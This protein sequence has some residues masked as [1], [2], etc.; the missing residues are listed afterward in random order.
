MKKETTEAIL[1]L[2]GEKKIIDY[3]DLA[4]EQQEELMLS[5]MN[6]SSNYTEGNHIFHK[7][8]TDGMIL[9][10]KEAYLG[11][12]EIIKEYFEVFRKREERK[13]GGMPWQKD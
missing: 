11:I 7:A 4:L 1:K 12:K 10:Y 3:R 8:Y 13:K 6:I 2:L 9:I 5:W